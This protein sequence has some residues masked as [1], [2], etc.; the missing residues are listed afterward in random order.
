MPR[1]E[2]FF[3]YSCINL[4]TAGKALCVMSLSSIS[5]CAT[6][7]SAG[8]H[9]SAT[10]HCKATSVHNQDIQTQPDGSW[11]SLCISSVSAAQQPIA[12]R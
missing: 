11:A 3:W 6:Q 5:L 8:I 7:S 4:V 9:G 1:W 2:I 10:A 12:R